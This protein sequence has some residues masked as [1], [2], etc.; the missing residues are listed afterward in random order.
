MN[1]CQRTGTNQR[2]EKIK[3]LSGNNG[4]CKLTYFGKVTLIRTGIRSVGFALSTVK[5]DRISGAM[6]HISS[7]AS[8]KVMKATQHIETTAPAVV[9]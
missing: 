5:S 9:G 7:V 1:K 6:N 4:L 8:M 3:G 2:T